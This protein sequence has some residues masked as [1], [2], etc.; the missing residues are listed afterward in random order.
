MA[1]RLTLSVLTVVL[2]SL[3]NTANA[4]AVNFNQLA[5]RC[6]SFVHPNTLQAVARVES[7]L[8]PYVIGVVNGR[9]K[10]QPQSRAEAV[11]MARFLDAQGYNFS[12]GLMQINKHNLSAL[13][14]NYDTAFD[15]CKNI[16]AGASILK[17]CLNR[18]GKSGQAAVQA[19]L[20]CYYGGNFTVRASYIQKVA[21]AAA[22]NSEQAAV[23]APAEASFRVQPAVLRLPSGRRP[24]AP[25]PPRNSSVFPKSSFAS[26]A[27][28]PNPVP[29]I[30]PS[31]ISQ[32]TPAVPPS[33]P[34]DVFREF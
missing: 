28:K 6:A 10:Q 2:S 15:L 30:P 29:P 17:E 33:A 9:L 8:H 14:L 18:S 27:P 11:Q 16:H 31:E 13:G 25:P 4:Q 23:K 26:A 22:A 19:A 34:W 21:N 7:N 32:D 20:S 12:L 1:S 24:L 5:R 3:A